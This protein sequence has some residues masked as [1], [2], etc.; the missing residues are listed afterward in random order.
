[1]EKKLDERSERERKEFCIWFYNETGKTPAEAME[2]SNRRALE[3]GFEDPYD[4][5]IDLTNKTQPPSP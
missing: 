5:V 2:E 1:M 4:E 3:E